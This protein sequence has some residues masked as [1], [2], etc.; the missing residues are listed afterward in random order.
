MTGPNTWVLLSLLGVVVGFVLLIACANLANLVLTRL[1]AR[2][3]TWRSG[4]GWAPLVL[5]W[6]DRSSSKA[7]SSG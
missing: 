2:R 4:R 7:C 5:S 3:R 6:C 1:V